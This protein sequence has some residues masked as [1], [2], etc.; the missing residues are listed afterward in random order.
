MAGHELLDFGFSFT[1]SAKHV[2]DRLTD[3]ADSE[4]VFAYCGRDSDLHRKL[5]D[6]L[7]VPP[8]EDD[9]QAR[10]ASAIC[11]L[12]LSMKAADA[13]HRHAVVESFL[14]DGWVDP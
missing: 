11:T 10:D 1:G 8:G 7:D 4:T 3:R 14:R 12:K 6:L 2:C 9:T 5:R 13:P